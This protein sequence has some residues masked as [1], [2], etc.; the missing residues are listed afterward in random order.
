MSQA[1]TPNQKP[2]SHRGGMFSTAKPNDIPQ[3]QTPK[4][5]H[6]GF[7]NVFLNSRQKP[8]SFRQ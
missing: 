7:V 8:T 3:V 6:F 1:T 4:Q 5:P 2:G